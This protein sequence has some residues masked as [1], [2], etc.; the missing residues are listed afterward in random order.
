MG[1]TGATCAA[2]EQSGWSLSRNIEVTNH[3]S[4]IHP[5][6]ST[7]FD[8]K[9]DTISTLSDF[10]L[11]LTLTPLGAVTTGWSQVFQVG[12]GSVR[13]PSL[14]VYDDLTKLHMSYGNSVCTP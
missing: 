9:I 4:C 11:S 3:A 12:S 7:N 6:S 14:W 2:Y 5:L 10:E 8:T 13:G 1:P